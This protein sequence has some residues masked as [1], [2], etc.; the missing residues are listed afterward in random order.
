M[1]CICMCHA[2][3]KV[4]N[5]SLGSQDGNEKHLATTKTEMPS[6]FQSEH[7]DHKMK[8]TIHDTT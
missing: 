3:V 4:L 7:S 1:T 8:T 5:A 2:P 6:L